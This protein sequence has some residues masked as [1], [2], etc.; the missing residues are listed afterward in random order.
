MSGS[1]NKN[2]RYELGCGCNAYFS[3][4]NSQKLLIG[5]VLT[6]MLKPTKSFG[7]LDTP[8]YG[9]AMFWLY[10]KCAKPQANTLFYGSDV[11]PVQLRHSK[12]ATA[13]E[14]IH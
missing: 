2:K 14:V 10:Q 6:G 12:V 11:H 3:F 5:N 1:D 4:R 8:D 9:P 13:P 7:D